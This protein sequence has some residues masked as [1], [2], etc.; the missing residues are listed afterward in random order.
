VTIW[1]GNSIAKQIIV[2]GGRRTELQH[3]S[4][5]P[6]IVLPLQTQSSSSSQLKRS[7]SNSDPRLEDAYADAQAALTRHQRELALEKKRHDYL[8]E[9]QKILELQAK[10]ANAALTAGQ[11]EVEMLRSRLEA[12]DELLTSAGLELP[13]ALANASSAVKEEQKEEACSIENVS[14][15]EQDLERA[16]ER[17]AVVVRPPVPLSKDQNLV[18]YGSG[19]VPD[20]CGPGDMIMITAAVRRMVAYL[21]Y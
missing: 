16:E 9:S 8:E 18:P 3:G 20:G 5:I 4:S 7:T 11:S 17:L 21:S 1:R 15:E 19:Q 12:A 14:N 2:E 13:E 10:E 6:D